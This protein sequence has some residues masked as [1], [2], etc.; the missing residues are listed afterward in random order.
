MFDHVKPSMKIYK[1]EIFGPVLSV[2]RAPDYATA[3]RA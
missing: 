3:A 2:V 1:E